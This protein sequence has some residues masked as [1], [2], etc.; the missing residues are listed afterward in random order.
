MGTALSAWIISWRAAFSIAAARS[1]G[2]TKQNAWV[3]DLAVPDPQVRTGQEHF[4][5]QARRL[6]A[7]PGEKSGLCSVADPFK[8]QRGEGFRFIFFGL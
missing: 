7:R 4:S 8:E 2:D 5:T 1:V 6:A 3:E